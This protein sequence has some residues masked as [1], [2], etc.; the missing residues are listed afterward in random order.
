MTDEVPD[1]FEVV[2]NGVGEFQL[3]PR[4]ANDP[5]ATGPASM[6]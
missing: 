1:G 5:L 6:A 3:P 2:G 4:L